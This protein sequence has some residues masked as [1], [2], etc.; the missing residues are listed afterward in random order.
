MKKINYGI[1]CMVTVFALFG[2]PTFL[3]TMNKAQQNFWQRHKATATNLFN[4]STSSISSIAQ[5]I[6]NVRNSV[7]QI[8]KFIKNQRLYKIHKT[9]EVI[10]QD[11]N[12]LELKSNP[13]ANTKQSYTS[14]LKDIAES[15][16]S[17]EIAIN[18]K[19]LL[20]K[21]IYLGREGLAFFHSIQSFFSILQ[22]ISPSNAAII[23]SLNSN[24][25]KC[26]QQLLSALKFFANNQFLQ[27]IEENILSTPIEIAAPAAPQKE[28]NSGYQFSF[29]RIMM[30]APQTMITLI[31]NIS[32]M[33]TANITN[34]LVALDKYFIK[35][36]AF[37]HIISDVWNSETGGA[38]NILTSTQES[39]TQKTLY[40]GITHLTRTA[41]LSASFLV[42][43][44]PISGLI[45]NN[46]G[47]I[48]NE[49]QKIFSILDASILAP[50]GIDSAREFISTLE[51]TKYELYELSLTIIN[52]EEQAAT[53][54]SIFLENKDLLMPKPNT[55]TPLEEKE[56][57]RLTN[58][59][60]TEAQKQKNA[61][62]K[63]E[64]KKTQLADIAAEVQKQKEED[65]RLVSEAEK[66][67]KQKKAEEEATEA[68]KKRE[69][70]EREKAEEAR[71]L[72]EQRKKQAEE[73]KRKKAKIRTRQ[74][75]RLAKQKEK[76]K[77][78]PPDI[79]ENAFELDSREKI[80]FDNP[81]NTSPKQNTLSTEAR[82]NKNQTALIPLN[83]PIIRSYFG[84]E[85][86]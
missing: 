20:L 65:Q 8:E 69:E 4:A 50:I 32:Q 17:V 27:N 83:Q 15:L 6:A 77:N 21:S 62:A 86:S 84:M 43:V 70:A 48:A 61:E 53:N 78:N 79:N 22:Q 58:E 39:I 42:F 25:D 47:N 38:K 68:Q 19:Q 56:T 52:A 45:L 10:K 59:K 28:E 54:N 5:K 7:S 3:V 46:F 74:K 57:D 63:E 40:E 1:I 85:P 37:F 67:K 29:Q 76:Q 44:V 23:F 73:A 71:Q 64:Q 72:E 36:N 81:S 41:N 30:T 35:L 31:K 14:M 26:L 24:I 16:N 80:F 51:T 66:A 49:L 18:K 2:R 12:A 33:P 34:A 9:I 75:N 13:Q 11:V 82:K 55:A 60:A